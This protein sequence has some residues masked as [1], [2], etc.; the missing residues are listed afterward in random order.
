MTTWMTT[1]SAMVRVR[2]M[3]METT[4][5]TAPMTPK[6]MKRNLLSKDKPLSSRISKQLL[7]A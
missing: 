6:R 4:S 5:M 1:C 3:K 2:M 7:T